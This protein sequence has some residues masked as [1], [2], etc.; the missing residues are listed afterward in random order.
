MDLAVAPQN[1][2]EI[3]PPENFALY[4][5]ERR[6][7]IMEALTVKEGKLTGSF[8]KDAARHAGISP[9]LLQKWLEH[10]ETYPNGPLGRFNR[11]ASKLIARSNDNLREQILVTA[12]EGKKWDGIARIGEQFDPSTWARPD[13]KSS[14]HVTVN[15]VDKLA[16]VHQQ[17][18]NPLTS[19]D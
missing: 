7:A 1:K 10:G 14:T 15:I 17:A 8:V 18:G 12:V 19:G 3:P 2:P 4:T 11:E 13:G 9:K 16:V 6:K 5:K